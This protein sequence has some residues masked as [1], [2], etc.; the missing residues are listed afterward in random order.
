MLFDY[1]G[2]GEWIA[3]ARRWALV[4][5]QH[6]RT[7]SMVDRGESPDTMPRQLAAARRARDLAP[8]VAAEVGAAKAIGLSDWLG[9]RGRER[10][11]DRSDFEPG[12]FLEVGLAV[13]RAVCL[14][15]LK[16]R[17]GGTILKGTGFLVAPGVVLT[18]HHVLLDEDEARNA[19]ITFDFRNDPY[20][21]PTPTTVFSL[22]PDGLFE[23]SAEYDCT[24]VS[25]GARVLGSFQ[26]A[27][28]GWLPLV[29][30]EGKV[31]VGDPINIIQHPRGEPMQWVVRGNRLLSLPELKDQR[32]PK[33]FAHYEADTLQ[34]SS[35]APAMSRLWEVF[36][37]HHQ[38]VP[39]IDTEG[40]PLDL[41]GE[42]YFGDDDSQVKWIGNE[43]I[44]VS[45]LV[46][47]LEERRRAAR[48]EK[49]AGIE[50]VLDAAR[51]DYIAL[52][53]SAHRPGSSATEGLQGGAMSGRLEFT[54]PLKISISL[55]DAK[56][57]V[58][59]A[60]AT[61]TT[62]GGTPR[63][64]SPRVPS[65]AAMSPSLRKQ[66][67]EALEELEKSRTRV[68]LDLAAI[69]A[70]DAAYYQGV[71]LEEDNDANFDAL[72]Q[73]LTATHRD[74][75]RYAPA[76]QLYPWID[77][78]KDGRRLSIKSIYSG[79]MFDAREFIEQAFA[80]EARRESLRASLRSN[81]AF[82]AASES[83]VDQLL[84]EM[85][86]YNCEHTVPQSWFQKKEPMR[87]DLHH[88]F[89]CESRCNSFRGNHAYFDFPDDEAT[90]EACGRRE[91][92]QFEPISG[93]GAVARATFYFLLRYPGGID[94]GVSQM[95][96][97]RVDT[98]KRWHA[99]DPVSD[100][101]RHRNQAIFEVQ[102]NRNPFIDHPDWA[103]R[104]ALA[105]GLE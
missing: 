36:A 32:D 42:P 33:V 16:D 20:G 40:N 3:A 90:M 23:T 92:D 105:K 51:P 104:V 85:A 64:P 22:N 80:I 60:V 74:K 84:E 21:R 57:V 81:E 101:E 4:R 25:V 2:R 47:L 12:A 7:R 103:R 79:K 55:G 34:G 58:D 30:A 100:Y 62:L 82:A 27:D 72:S 5:Q 83:V 65:S 38:A 48:P 102:G 8:T 9:T 94:L 53:A 54:L 49:V 93:T 69:A 24:F 59:S 1:L 88:L 56:D 14:V 66:K 52:A 18:N 11:I 50:Q 19:T 89:A 17:L 15:E 78:H 37:L 87:G 96:S 77:L 71:T 44:R 98:L 99:G 76:K 86:P 61:I 97:D 75:P 46:R 67:D 39:A 31:E 91:E 68:Y 29:G 13:G 95:D 6:E 45:A 70:A 26:V 35:G 41:N 28:F 10:L 63:S 43:G 73:L